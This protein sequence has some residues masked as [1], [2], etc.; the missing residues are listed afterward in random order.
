VPAPP[1]ADL[2]PVAAP[3]TGAVDRL[4]LPPVAETVEL[5]PVAAVVT[6]DVPPNGTGDE[7][8]AELPP[9][10]SVPIPPVGLP[11]T[12]E[13]VPN[14]PPVPP[15]VVTVELDLPPVCAPWTVEAAPPVSAEL[16]VVVVLEEQAITVRT[17]TALGVTT[18]R[19]CM[20]F[21]SIQR[22]ASWGPRVLPSTAPFAVFAEECAA[23]DTSAHTHGYSSDF[24]G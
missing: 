9:V 21:L 20:G 24:R 23:D 4:L 19:I 5:P 14:A 11:P 16:P 7:P 12:C 15:W 22:T 6:A 1:T 17:M 13:L 8:P 10:P 2:P 3:P 18:A